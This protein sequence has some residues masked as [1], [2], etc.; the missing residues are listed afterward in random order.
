MLWNSECCITYLHSILSNRFKVWSLTPQQ[1]AQ[2]Q[3][4]EDGYK[5]RCAWSVINMWVRWPKHALSKTF[6]HWNSRHL[7]WFDKKRYHR[8]RLL[9]YL[10]YV[11]FLVA[12]VIFC[13][14]VDRTQKVINRSLWNSYQW[15]GLAYLDAIKCWWWSGPRHFWMVMSYPDYKCN[16]QRCV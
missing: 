8:E 9:W 13:S 15:R 1:T 6:W 12:L 16:S 4:W 10:P 2:W 14:L 11:M 3:P 5:S 7:F